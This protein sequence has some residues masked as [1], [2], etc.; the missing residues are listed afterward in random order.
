ML[1]TVESVQQG[2]LTVRIDGGSTDEARHVTIAA[3]EYAS[4][5]HG[6]ATTIHKAQG[7]TVDR[8]FVLASGRMDGH[9]AYVGLT[10][11]RHEARL[12]GDGLDVQRL[13]SD[14]LEQIAG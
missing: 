9:L 3:D 10:R 1:G 12:Y 7:A 13:T 8:A 5:D 6:Y 14:P 2:K 11:H 4:F